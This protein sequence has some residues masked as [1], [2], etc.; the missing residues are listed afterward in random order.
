MHQKAFQEVT[1]SG[2]EGRQR[3]D[4]SEHAP[5]RAP[6]HC[7]YMPQ[8]YFWHYKVKRAFKNIIFLICFLWAKISKEKHKLISGKKQTTGRK[9]SRDVFAFT[10]ESLLVIRAFQASIIQDV[11]F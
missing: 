4:I 6:S 11:K 8:I 5:A 1:I 2:P 9:P 3:A 10:K 7:S